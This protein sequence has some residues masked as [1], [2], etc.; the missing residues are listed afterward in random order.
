MSRSSRNY[1]SA[2]QSI[3][4]IIIVL[5]RSLKSKKHFYS[6]T[7]LLPG[8]AAAKI[9]AETERGS[10]CSAAQPPTPLSVLFS[11]Y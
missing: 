1:D 2:A 6:L 8:L 4:G 9:G 7:E 10:N 3:I 5:L 11:R